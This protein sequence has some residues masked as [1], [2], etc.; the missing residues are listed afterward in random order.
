VELVV[1]EQF[2]ELVPLAEVVPVGEVVPVVVPGAPELLVVVPG[3][4]V[5]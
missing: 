1:E 2:V 5:V 4:G 3:T